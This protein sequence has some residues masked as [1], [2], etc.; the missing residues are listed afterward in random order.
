MQ[1]ALWA[2]LCGQHIDSHASFE[3][4]RGVPVEDLLRILGTRWTPMHL[5]KARLACLAPR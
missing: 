1:E 3:A 4:L 5:F 2:Q